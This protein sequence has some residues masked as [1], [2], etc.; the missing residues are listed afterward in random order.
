MFSRPNKSWW[1]CTDGTVPRRTGTIRAERDS[2][3]AAHPTER[4]PPAT[5]ASLGPIDDEIGEVHFDAS[6][7]ERSGDEA[8]FKRRERPV[9]HI[10]G[11]FPVHVQGQMVPDARGRDFVDRRPWAMASAHHNNLVEP[12]P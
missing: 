6:V 10:G 3:P 2:T 5:Q 4:K 12:T 1:I 8:H 7:H 9:A 11:R